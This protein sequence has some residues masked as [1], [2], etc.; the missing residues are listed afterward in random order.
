MNYIVETIFFGNL[1]DDGSGCGIYTILNATVD[2]LTIGIGILA[3]IGIMIAGIKYLTAKGNEK[4]VEKAKHRIF[5]IAVGLAAY[6]LLYVGIQFLLPGGKLDFGQRCDT[7]SDQELAQIKEEQQQ[8]QQQ[9]SSASQ[10]SSPSSSSSSSSS[11]STTTASLDKWFTAMKD[12]AKYMKNA[13]YGTN[14]KHKS[15]G[16]NY[17]SNFE[18][19]KYSGTCITFVS[20]A[21]QR[22]GVIPKNK[23]VWLKESGKITGT[24]ASFIKKHTDTFKVF[25]PNKTIKQLKKEN[26]IQKGDIIAYNYNRGKNNDRSHIMVFMGFDKKG[27]P[28]FNTFGK[29]G[30]GMGVTHDLGSKVKINMIIRLKKTSL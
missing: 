27:K 3:V 9:H 24:A 30:L 16:T 6:A 15:C 26:N 23:Y 10:S 11:S 5:Q 28:L 22:L 14:P 21:L 20:T 25:Y 13:T 18:C 4:Q 8:Q 12:Q 19:S 7:I 17:G 1:K 29:G 2:L